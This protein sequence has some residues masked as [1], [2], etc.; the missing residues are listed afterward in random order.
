MKIFY[1]RNILPYLQALLLI[2]FFKKIP[3][4]QNLTLYSSLVPKTLPQQ[5]VVSVQLYRAGTDGAIGS[6]LNIHLE[7]HRVAVGLC[8]GAWRKCQQQDLGHAF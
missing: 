1:N 4:L 7:T 5:E 3:V 2:L 8:P 6:N